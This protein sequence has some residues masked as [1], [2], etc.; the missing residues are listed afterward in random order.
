MDQRKFLEAA[1]E[2]KEEYSSR[3]GR[4]TYSVSGKSMYPLLREGDRVNVRSAAPRE[5]SIGDIVLWN[6][7]W[8]F[9][10]LPVLHRVVYKKNV[11]GTY[12]YKTKGDYHTWLDP[13][14][15]SFAQ[16]KGKVAFIS[17][18]AAVFR[19][20]TLLGNAAS[21]AFAVFAWILAL[22]RTSVR[23]MGNLAAFMLPRKYGYASRNIVANF[24]DIGSG[25]GRWASFEEDYR[26]MLDELNLSRRDRV[27]ELHMG[28]GRSEEAM[29]I[30]RR[31]I[32]V[33]GID[34]FD[35]ERDTAGRGKYDIVVIP[36][37]LGLV[38]SKNERI[39][40]C[41]GVNGVMEKG[42][43][44]FVTS[45]NFKMTLLD[46]CRALRNRFPV[47]NVFWEKTFA[48]P[49]EVTVNDTFLHGWF[50]KDA[51]ASDI[52]DS[53]YSIALVKETKYFIG[54]VAIYEPI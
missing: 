52:R 10:T 5:I 19:L 46:R 8:V 49:G 11:R 12:L 14:W 25:V 31:G 38:R 43:R 4:Y 44:I 13:E 51:L 17:K 18:G 37:V 16:I 40:I 35:L 7:E 53:G 32:K 48:Q 21:R 6:S 9:K 23:A 15:V 45:Y 47:K 39:G 20:D 24:V 30:I 1:L 29:E 36:R 26:N 33:D 28:T 50:G 3:R 41:K 42:S 34:M 27:A 2:L 22:L 54:M